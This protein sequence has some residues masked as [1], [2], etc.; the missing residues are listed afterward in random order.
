MN[1]I[2]DH[3]IAQDETAQDY[4]MPRDRYREETGKFLI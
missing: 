4:F 1:A 3:E 2:N